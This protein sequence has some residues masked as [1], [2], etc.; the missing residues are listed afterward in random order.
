MGNETTKTRPLWGDLEW[1][2]LK[3]EGIDIGCGGDPVL[4]TAMPFDKGQGD[5]NRIRDYVHRQFDFVYSS[6]CLEHMED[7]ARAMADW[8]SLV[9]PGGALFLIVPD[10]DLYEQG[11]WPSRFNPDHKWTFTIAKHRSWSPVSINLLDLV[12][13]LPDGEVIDLRL[14]D[15]GY[16]RHLASNGSR[17]GSALYAVKRV[18]SRLAY[19]VGRL[20]GMDKAALKRALIHPTDQ[21]AL[22]G[23]L[24]QIQC[25]V[26]R[27]G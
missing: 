26:R 2:V 24:A 4:P 23:R 19:G 18:A 12:R 8:W 21:T 6:H 17:V 14:H 16:E 13:K 22:P 25:I 20:L 9:K 15:E 7:P 10:E 5:C 27:Q 1:S 3:G 11:Y